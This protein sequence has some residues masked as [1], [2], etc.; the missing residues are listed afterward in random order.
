MCLVAVIE[1]YILLELPREVLREMHTG[2]KNTTKCYGTHL[3]AIISFRRPVFLQHCCHTTPIAQVSVRCQQ[4][5]L[6]VYETAL[7]SSQPIEWVTNVLEYRR[8][9]KKGIISDKD[10][11]TTIMV[12]MPRYSGFTK[13]GTTPGGGSPTGIMLDGMLSR[14]MWSERMRAL[15]SWFEEGQSMLKLTV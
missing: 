9:R 13:L 2:R 5:I 11:V 6:S 1:H 8:R 15:N 4:N 12:S 7:Q 10:I 3:V 14:S